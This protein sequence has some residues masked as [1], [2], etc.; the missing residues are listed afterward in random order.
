MLIFDRSWHGRV[1][2]E[3]IE[4]FASRDEWSR[5]YDEIIDF[6]TQLAEHEM[7]VRKF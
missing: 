7:L 6:E 1:L 5:A 2:V 3:R 4:G